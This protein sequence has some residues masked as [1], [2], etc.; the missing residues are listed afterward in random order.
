MFKI[1]NITA[2]E[3]KRVRLSPVMGTEVNSLDENIVEQDNGDLTFC[4]APDTSNDPSNILG[5]ALGLGNSYSRGSLRMGA[6]LVKKEW[7]PEGKDFLVFIGN[8]P[9]PES[10]IQGYVRLFADIPDSDQKIIV[11][12]TNYEESP[13]GEIETWQVAL[14]IPEGELI[15]ISEWTGIWEATLE[16]EYI[17]VFEENEV[18]VKETYLSFQVTE[19]HLLPEAIYGDGYYIPQYEGE[20]IMVLPSAGEELLP[21]LS[22]TYDP[23][24]NGNGSISVMGRIWGDRRDGEVWETSYG[25]SAAVFGKV[26]GVHT[27]IFQG[28][29]VW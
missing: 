4:L 20:T 28:R 6:I 25:L 22:N 26:N 27:G 23:E 10:W 13:T 2:D 21:R 15:I 18:D 17:N 8:K 5:I 29:Y 24:T 19:N 11:F 14:V 16:P 3:H 7:N 1:K 9:D 12:D